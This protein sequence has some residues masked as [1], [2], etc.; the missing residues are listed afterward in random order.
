MMITKTK[1]QGF[2]LIELT[3]ASAILGSLLII[4]TQVFIGI[5]RQQETVVSMQAASQNVRYGLDDIVSTARAASAVVVITNGSATPPAIPTTF[6]QIC[7]AVGNNVVQYFS[8]NPNSAGLR[9]RALYKRT[10]GLIQGQSLASLC[11]AISNPNGSDTQLVSTNNPANVS[12]SG[13]NVSDFRATAVQSAIPTITVRLAIT[14]DLAAIDPVT[15]QCST[16]QATAPYCS[17]AADE[18][19]ISLRGT[20][21]YGP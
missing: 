9:S 7:F 16:N 19:T 5:V 10:I 14:T 17:I 11:T 20:Q 1:Q 13:L 6:N 8:A 2:T 15:L 21:S 3:L 12:L 18:T 4:I